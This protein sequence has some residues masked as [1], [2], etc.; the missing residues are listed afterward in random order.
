[1]STAG[2]EPGAICSETDP[3]KGVA[4]LK[5]S[6]V[7]ARPSGQV[8][9][10]MREWAL[11]DW[12]ELAAFAVIRA[13]CCPNPSPLKLPPPIGIC[14]PL[15]ESLDALGAAAAAH[16]DVEAGITRVRAAVHCAIAT[17]AVA[18]YSYKDRPADGAETILRKTIERAA[19]A[20][21]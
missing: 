20:G 6:V 2:I 8:T 21:L 1:E 14:E 12:Y 10:A 4:P 18:S 9:E 3:R 13:R 7:R 17:G 16:G 11:L 5:P 19:P 15:D